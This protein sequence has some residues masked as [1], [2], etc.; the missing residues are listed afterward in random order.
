MLLHEQSLIRGEP[1]NMRKRSRSSA[2]PVL[3]SMTS[4]KARAVAIEQGNLG[5]TRF[6]HRA[7]PTFEMESASNYLTCEGPKKRGGAEAPPL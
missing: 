6:N 2:S 3:V 4:G 1:A 7:A 5:R